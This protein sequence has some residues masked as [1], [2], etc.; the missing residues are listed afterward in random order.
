MSRSL[1][2][3]IAFLLIAFGLSWLVSLPL[4]FGDGLQTPG[5]VFMALGMM[6][7]PAIAALVVVF[8]IE[9]PE[10]RAYALGLWPLRPVKRLLGYLGLG[11]VVPI[12]LILVALPVGAWLG[13]YP[14]DFVTFSAFQQTIDAQL[15]AVGVGSL[16][17]PIGVLVALQFVNVL[18]GAVINIGPAL[19]E[20]LGW[21]GWLLPKLMP[22]GAVPAIVLS[23][24]IWG[25][26][27]APLLLLG[28][29]YPGS[30]GWLGVLM[31]VGMCSVIGAVFGWLRLR[32]D[33]VWPA[34]LA[35]GA[36]NAAAGFSLVF[37]AA[38]ERVDPVQATILG[39]SGWLV[40]LV[41][42]AVLVATGQFSRAPAPLVS[43]AAETVR[44]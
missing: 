27:H 8:F 32:S 39:W 22:L 35:H 14:A 7:T 19:G 37:A 12:A 11:L 16:G 21:R 23:G 3:V 9:K 43:P 1:R 6:T 41:L 38:G 5:F 36:F 18:I 10:R 24:V 30:P 28:Y 40:P 13:V 33:S 15:D 17:I 26:W 29:N 44:G 20:E 42:V 2:P 4:W 34:A 31:M 25:V